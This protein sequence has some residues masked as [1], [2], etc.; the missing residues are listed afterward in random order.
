MAVAIMNGS[1]VR[2]PVDI[3]PQFQKVVNFKKMFSVATR[4]TIQKVSRGGVEKHFRSIKTSSSAQI[5]IH[6]N[7]SL[8]QLHTDLNFVEPLMGMLSS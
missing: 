4:F 2:L 8:I 1:F 6:K 3:I 7:K 5:A